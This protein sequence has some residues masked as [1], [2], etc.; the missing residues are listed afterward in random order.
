MVR[1][2]AGL[3][4]VAVAVATGSAHA[5]WTSA[6]VPGGGTV[7]VEVNLGAPGVAAVAH[8]GGA[9][10]ARR[11]PD[12]GIV[13]G[14]TGFGIAMAGARAGPGDCLYGSVAAGNSP[15]YR[16]DP[17]GTCGADQ[18]STSL[19]GSIAG[20]RLVVTPNGGAYAL[21]DDTA[22]S[23]Y[24]TY[25]GDAGA[26]GPW[27]VEGGTRP[28]QT[29]NVQLSATSLG[30]TDYCVV[31]GAGSVFDL[32]AGLARVPSGTLRSP[33]SV[34]VSTFDL[35]ARGATLGLVLASTDGGLWV[36]SDL[37]AD[38]GIAWT[39]ADAGP[40]G[41]TQI[42]AFREEGGGP[43]GRGFGLAA[44]DGGL[45]GAVPNPA[46]PGV[47]WVPRNAAQAPDF[48]TTWRLRC[49]GPDECV[50]ANLV[51][52]GVASN[53]VWY[54]N[55]APPSLTPPALTV[56][57]NGGATQLTLAST[58]PDGD[59]VWVGVA[60]L[61][62]GGTVVPAGASL[63]LT[64]LLGPATGY[65]GKQVLAQ[66]AGFACGS[67]PVRVLA[68]SSDGLA[69]HVASAEV[70]LQVDRL[71]PPGTPEVSP[72]AVFLKAGLGGQSVTAAD[73]DAGCPATSFS[74]GAAPAGAPF[75]VVPSG[76]SATL[77]PAAYHCSLDAGPWPVAVGASNSA[78][79]AD[80]G[81]SV[82]VWVEPWG[83]PTTPVWE[84]GSAAELAPGADASYLLRVRHP[85]IDDAGTNWPN[86]FALE[87]QFSFL[88]GGGAFA[89]ASCGAS[90]PAVDVAC[91]AVAVQVTHKDVC[92]SGVVTISATT[93]RL[94][95]DAG[96]VSPPALLTLFV[97]AGLTPLDA[98][99]YDA[100]AAYRAQDAVVRVD[101]SLEGV[102]CLAA[103]GLFSEVTVVPLGG[104]AVAAGPVDLALGEARDV[105]VAGGCAGG[106]FEVRARLMS[107]AGATGL[108]ARRAFTAPRV[109]AGVAD[110]TPKRVAQRCG[111]DL[112]FTLAAVPEPW[113]CTDQAY[114]WRQTGGAA[115]AV[116]SEGQAVRVFAADPDFGALAAEPLG[117]ALAADAGPA[118]VAL[119][120]DVAVR[121]EP[122]PFVELSHTYALL[123]AQ[124]GEAHEVRA[125][126]ALAPGTSGRC[127][128]DG[129]VLVEEL[130]RL[131][132]VPGSARLDGAPVDVQLD[133]GALAVGPLSLA[134]G[135]TVEVRWL[136]RTPLLGRV[137][138]GD[139]S[140]VEL[141]GMP[142]S[143]TPTRPACS[144]AGAPGPGAVA[145]A[146]ALLALR[147]RRRPRG[148]GGRPS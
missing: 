122:V 85:C 119:R 113:A 110:W 124:E 15:V 147:R 51:A 38:A 18:D 95:E 55:E 2:A 82:L 118:N 103:R 17:P 106:D 148:P 131:R 144:C 102:N 109:D 100:G 28:L 121:V 123:P 114:A 14:P 80:G 139:G 1:Q 66:A 40:G 42:V 63:T 8:D 59:P 16:S 130:G 9:N 93:Q 77:L 31:H 57:P 112:D 60:A 107:D 3:L 83:T 41:R 98:G 81:T 142:V 62:D 34:P 11:L 74:W 39:G 48:T 43:L 53:L 25:H 72:G 50:G 87:G 4:A 29:A 58:D 70:A 136:A 99:A 69:T 33:N 75:T 61:P 111:E 146:A 71:E 101:T 115:V 92:Q 49:R 145:L 137:R 10:V 141:A 94:G 44:T 133:G 64:P 143:V 140:R 116:D 125:Q 37:L 7:P 23:H 86:G 35:Y 79:V 132:Y 96:R 126:L 45:W 36:T 108:E 78:G 46:A 5:G 129:L 22:S 12:G 120:P 26:A 30:S 56:V 68:T 117:F 32:V 67:T 47:Y 21:R 128:A 97:D 13:F 105:R 65:E 127:R 73:G 91:T 6:A 138:V 54:V 88:D 27:D 90:T 20:F 76:A 104:G 134:P 52:G 89:G 24:L 84:A 135:V 19:P